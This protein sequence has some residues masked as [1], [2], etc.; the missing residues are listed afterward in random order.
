[1]AMIPKRVWEILTAEEREELQ[2]VVDGWRFSPTFRCPKCDTEVQIRLR[3]QATAIIHPDSE[4]PKTAPKY[5]EQRTAVDRRV[6]EAART[7]GLMDAFISAVRAEKEHG[8]IPSDM[9]EFFLLFWNTAKPSPVS[10]IVLATWRAEFGGWIDVWQSQGVIAVMS[11][12]ELVA[13][14]P[15]RLTQ[16]VA[17]AGKGPR[18][19]VSNTASFEMWTKNKWGYVP[20]SARA[21]G[22]ALRQRNIG[23]FGSSV[24]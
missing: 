24:Q 22:E 19:K 14:F 8:G 2:A 3:A 1:M 4:E 17:I 5:I 11:A 12:G 21:F 20:M 6:I 16:P 13:F 9:D 15:N 7:S 10:A 23:A 18:P